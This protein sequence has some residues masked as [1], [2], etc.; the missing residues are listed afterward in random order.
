MLFFI[1]ASRNFNFYLFFFPPIETPGLV[2]VVAVDEGI[3]EV[4]LEKDTVLVDHMN[5]HLL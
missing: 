5:S 3:I 1:V 4:L 2:E